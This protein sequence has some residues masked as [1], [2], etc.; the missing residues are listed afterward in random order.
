MAKSLRFLGHALLSELGGLDDSLDLQWKIRN[1]E[2]NLR[3]KK[4][5]RFWFSVMLFDNVSNSSRILAVKSA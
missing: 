5:N 1:S 2:A 4:R 3:L